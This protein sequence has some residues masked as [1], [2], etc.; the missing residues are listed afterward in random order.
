MVP[1]PVTSSSS[2]SHVDGFFTNIHPELVDKSISSLATI[3]KR[4]IKSPKPE[5]SG[6]RDSN[7]RDEIGLST[8]DSNNAWYI[9]IL[10]RSNCAYSR[11]II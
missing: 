7:V 8:I 1:I 9:D 2:S 5:G 6:G 11:N 3:L 10:V 4:T